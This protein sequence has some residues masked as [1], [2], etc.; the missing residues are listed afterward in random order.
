M[1]VMCVTIRV[2]NIMFIL[3]YIESACR[4][5]MDPIGIGRQSR[6][7]AVDRVAACAQL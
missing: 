3:G 7:G 6:S 5:H 4:K 1:M 2:Y